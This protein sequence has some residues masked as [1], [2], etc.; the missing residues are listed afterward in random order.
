[1]PQG[2]QYREWHLFIPAAAHTLYMHVPGCVARSMYR[3]TWRQV[4]V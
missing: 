2:W 1:M 3:D 4:E